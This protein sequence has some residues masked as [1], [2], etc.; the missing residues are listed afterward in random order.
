[1]G[2]LPTHFLV[3]F[4]SHSGMFLTTPLSLCASPPIQATLGGTVWTRAC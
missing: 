3:Q 1:M 4:H 2:V